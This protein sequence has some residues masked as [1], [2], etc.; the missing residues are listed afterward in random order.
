MTNHKSKLLSSS[1]RSPVTDVVERL[2]PKIA[3]SLE[4]GESQ[5]TIYKELKRA[6]HSVGAWPSSFNHALRHFKPELDELRARIRSNENSSPIV[7]AENEMS[8]NDSVV[9]SVGTPTPSN[10]ADKNAPSAGSVQVIPATANPAK[11]RPFLLLCANDTGG[12]GSTTLARVF[13][14]LFKLASAQS[15]V[16]DADP[17]ERQLSNYLPNAVKLPEVVTGTHAPTFI[18]KAAGR[19]LIIDVG[20]NDKWLSPTGSEGLSAIV[21]GFAE[22]GYECLCFMPVMPTNPRD[23]AKLTQIANRFPSANPFLVLNNWRSTAYP[24]GVDYVF[25]TIK[26]PGAGTYFIQCVN[27]TESRSLYEAIAKAGAVK[28]NVRGPL[29]EWLHDFAGNL[30]YRASLASAIQHLDELRASLS[31]KAPD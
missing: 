27:D 25:P 21:E 4:V 30:P 8:A 16:I 29:A 9:P 5:R 7:S 24:D 28:N 12:Q 10:A 18:Q 3:R 14:A 19:H 15:V 22:A 26:L 13:H 23:A 2:L 11:M 20:S 17:G 6:G 31:G 1:S